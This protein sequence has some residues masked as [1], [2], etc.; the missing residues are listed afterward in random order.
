MYRSLRA[1][2]QIFPFPVIST[3]YLSHVISLN[4]VVSC[5]CIR[6]LRCEGLAQTRA[7]GRGGTVY[8]ASIYATWQ[9]PVVAIRDYALHF[10]V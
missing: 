2:V 6:V 9:Y 4:I 7:E 3:T 5:N 10:I 8:R 1:L